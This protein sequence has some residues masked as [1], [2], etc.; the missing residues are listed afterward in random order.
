MKVV[1]SPEAKQDLWE[2]WTYIAGDSPESADRV[3]LDLQDSI[4]KLSQFPYI[5]VPRSDL[6]TGLRGLVVKNY[7]IFYRVEVDVMVARVLHGARDI[8]AVLNEDA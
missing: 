1:I 8:P 7:I 5:G 3:Y 4:R 2:I 6:L